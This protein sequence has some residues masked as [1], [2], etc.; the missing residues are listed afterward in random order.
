MS[1]CDHVAEAKISWLFSFY[2]ICQKTLV[3]KHKWITF[4]ESISTKYWN[5]ITIANN[6]DEQIF[7][8]VMPTKQYGW[9]LWRLQ[10]AANCQ[11]RTLTIHY[12]AL[13]NAMYFMEKWSLFNVRNKFTQHKDPKYSK[14]YNKGIKTVIA[15]KF[16]NAGIFLIQVLS[17]KH[18]EVSKYVWSIDFHRKI[19]KLDQFYVTFR[20]AVMN[21]YFF[22]EILLRSDSPLRKNWIAHKEGK[23]RLD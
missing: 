2:W 20:C 5:T 11:I 15:K 10:L 23:A 18:C 4:T 9:K 16:S 8:V 1:F 12:K 21:E 17:V 7:A 3:G 19:N 6:S 13:H 22:L 14:V